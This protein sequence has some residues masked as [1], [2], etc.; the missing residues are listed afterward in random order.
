MEECKG[1]VFYRSFYEAVKDL[2]PEEFKKAVS[3]ILEYGLNGLEPESSGGIEWMVYILTKPQLDANQKRRENGE[4][5]GRPAIGTKPAKNQTITKENPNPNQTEANET[6]TEPKEKEKVKE[7][8]KAKVKEKEK[9]KAAPEP[10]K[11]KYGEF[12]NV[13]LTGDEFK[14][15]VDSLGSKKA[16]D[17]IER[18]SVYVAQTGK[19][20]QNHYAT[21]L[22]WARKDGENGRKESKGVAEDPNNGADV[23]IPGLTVL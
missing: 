23:V 11:E 20:Y 13:M 10:K 14:K 18:V 15:L 8:D 21:I 22:N 5:G 19:R 7:K 4:K 2:P 3:A 1:I 16:S 17:Y 9:D 6:E 12:E